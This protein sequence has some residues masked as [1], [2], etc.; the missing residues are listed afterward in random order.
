MNIQTYCELCKS[1]VWFQLDLE[2]IS[3]VG[4]GIINRSLIHDG[5]VL[6]CEI[7]TQGS[8]R[9]AR[10]QQIL[11]NPTDT[12]SKRVARS[13]H[14]INADKGQTIQMDVYTSNP[15][16]GKFFNDVL[17]EMIKQISELER[18]GRGYFDI[19]LTNKLTILK[20]H[21]FDI[22]I[23]LNIRLKEENLQSLKG[24]ILDMG[25][26]EEN[27]VDLEIMVKNQDFVGILTHKDTKDPYFH[28]ISS[29]CLSYGIPFYLDSLSTNSLRGLFD[30]I[31]AVLQ[32]AN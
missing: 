22:S 27:K 15:E 29:L 30:F 11:E 6:N 32:S 1:T 9:S 16:L 5:H 12:L 21:R 28:A 14:E 19:Y 20:T 2:N 17:G 25:D 10:A 23:G 8:V 31:Y 13:F 4:S 3:F 24:L 26:V 7:D 18:A